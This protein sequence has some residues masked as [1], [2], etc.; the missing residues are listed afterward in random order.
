MAERNG[1]HSGRVHRDLF[2]KRYFGMN[3][4]LPINSVM[5]VQA[6]SEI[7]RSALVSS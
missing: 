4:S 7:A 5:R 3:R 6:A 2:T 1:Q